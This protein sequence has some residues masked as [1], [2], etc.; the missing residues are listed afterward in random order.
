MKNALLSLV[1]LSA[2]LPAGLDAFWEVA[3]GEVTLETDFAL[4]HDSNIDGNVGGRSDN[5]ARLTPT[6]RFRREAGRGTID[7]RVSSTIERYDKNDSEDDENYA[8]SLNIGLPTVEGSPLSGS[9]GLD[10]RDETSLNDTLNQRTSR[11]SYGGNLDLAYRYSERLGLTGGLYYDETNTEAFSD[12]T[13]YGGDLGVQY[14]RRTGWAL[15]FS[16][17]LSREESDGQFGT[18]VDD[19]NHSFNFGVSGQ[20]TPKLNGNASI[21]YQINDDS[22]TGSDNGSIV[23]SAA[24]QWAARENTDVNLALSRATQ[25]SAND[26][27]VERTDI[28]LTVNQR[29]TDKL[30]ASLG[31]FYSA[32]SFRGADRDE[33]EYGFDLGG[34]YTF[35]RRWSAAASVSYTNYETDGTDVI[36]GVNAPADERWVY[37][38][39]TRFTF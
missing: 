29:L 26:Q 20:L 28:D 17:A 2:L 23:A 4:T 27:S 1:L 32:E 16:Y 30:S 18:A 11:Q 12:T 31:L 35:T 6:L 3:E 5:I 36:T 21:G 13:N 37:S 10:Y 7:A 33:S 9:F 34:T 25:A 38:L 24:L 39:S 15:T 19:T 14:F 22:A 8:A